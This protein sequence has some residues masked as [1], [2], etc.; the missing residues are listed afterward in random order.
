MKKN[1]VIIV[2]SILV[3]GLGGFIIYD[4][5]L[6]KNTNETNSN[7]AN[8]QTNTNTNNLV[9]SIIGEQINL[10][11]E[12]EQAIIDNKLSIELIG[13]EDYTDMYVYTAKIYYDG[14]EIENSL[15]TDVNNKVIWSTNYAASFRV[16]KVNNVYFI[17]SSISKQNDGDYVLIINE[18]KILNTF[19]DVKIVL[20]KDNKLFEV[21]DC[22]TGAIDEVCS[23]TK[24]SVLE[25]SI[26][27]AK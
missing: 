11:K 10:S 19:V 12:K 9:T 15:F 14:K 26:E 17:I 4:K 5:I 2:L 6:N 7:T 27:I 3:L 1:I 22:T 23:A 20:D 25:N 21:S 16:E 18:G 24:Y 8:N 13:V